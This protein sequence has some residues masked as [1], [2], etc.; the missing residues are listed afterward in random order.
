VDNQFEKTDADIHGAGGSV[1]APFLKK[2]L[3][4]AVLFSSQGF[5]AGSH[6]LDSLLLGLPIDTVNSMRKQWSGRFHQETLFDERTIEKDSSRSFSSLYRISKLGLE[7]K[8]KAA[9]SGEDSSLVIVESNSRW[10]NKLMGRIQENVFASI[11]QS[12]GLEIAGTHE[13][14]RKSK[15]IYLGLTLI[16]CGLGLAYLDHHSFVYDEPPWLA[17]GNGSGE[18]LS[19]GFMLSDDATLRKIGMGMYAVYKLLG[20]LH[21]STLGLHNEFTATG[22]KYYF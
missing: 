12:Y 10:S 19:I 16:N 3:L 4:A 6:R 1:K 14:Q 15:S 20:L 11:S 22:Y 8:F 21:L 18:I 9:Q 13:Y 2:C 17:I 7:V 5:A